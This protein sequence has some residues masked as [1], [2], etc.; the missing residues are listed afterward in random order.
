MLLHVIVNMKYETIM[1]L[2]TS[3]NLVT[4]TTSLYAQLQNLKVCTS[5]IPVY[6]EVV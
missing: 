6:V 1:T 4:L 2:Q 3:Q 5:I